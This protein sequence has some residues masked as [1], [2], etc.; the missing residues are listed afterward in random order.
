MT[1]ITVGYVPCTQDPP[2]GKNIGR[3]WAEAVRE[4]LLAEKVG[5]DNVLFS[6]HHQQEDAYLPNPLLLAGL[7]GA[8]TTRIRVGTGVL[9]L[10]LW[11]PVH[12][13]ED[14]AVVDVATGGR[15]ILGVGIGYQPA[16]FDAFGVPIAE[17]AKRAEETIEVVKRCWSG[18]RVSFSGRYHSIDGVRVTPTPA[19]KPRP[20]IWMAAWTDAGLRRAARIADGWLA[21]PIQSLEVIRRFAAA[22]RA[23]AERRGKKPFVVLPRDLWVSETAR[24]AR[25]E[26]DPMMYT[27]RFYFRHGAYVPDE[28]TRGVGSESEWTFERA[29]RDRFVVGSPEEC[30]DQLAR[31]LEEVRPDCLVLR[32]RHPGG[33]PHDRVMRAI[34]AF[35]EKILPRL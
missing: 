27:H 32:M 28:H 2:L 6:E 29:A 4:T 8:R 31:W 26:A 30:R 1:M 17:R 34:R 18:D 11:H 19:Q 22:Y 12:L 35:G 21:D 20:P 10:P 23:E 3:V 13:A 9:L 5:F 24:E 7:A 16:D 33:P 14:A 25:A 15:L